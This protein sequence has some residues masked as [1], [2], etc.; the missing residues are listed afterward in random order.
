MRRSMMAVLLLL[1]SCTGKDIPSRIND[2]D[3]VEIIDTK[4]NFSHIE[5]K[6]EIIR[7]FKKAFENPAEPT[8]CSPQGTILFR[9]GNKTVFKAGYY[10]DASACDFFIVEEG[11]KK[12]GYRYSYNILAYLGVYFQKLK[13][14]HNARH[15]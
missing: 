10:K 3:R 13:Q 14:E 1:F 15:N 2:A 4:T 7:E 5:T 11:G 9:N 6:P 8:D 12:M